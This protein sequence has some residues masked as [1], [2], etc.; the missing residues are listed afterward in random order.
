MPQEPLMF[1]S[2]RRLMSAAGINSIH[3][4]SMP[5]RRF[6]FELDAMNICRDAGVV[7]FQAIVFAAMSVACMAEVA[8]AIEGVPGGKRIATGSLYTC[9]ITEIGEVRCWGA[10]QNGELGDGSSLN[11]GTPTT[12]RGINEPVVAIA[13]GSYHVCV[14]TLSGSV[15]C[16]GLNTQGQLGNNS[17][18]ASATPVDAVGLGSGIVS[19]TAGR[20]HT[21][22]LSAT[23]E[24]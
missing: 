22:A 10:G 11:R 4:D 9:A 16:W 3:L 6:P 15:K 2:K 12:V 13:G 7:L 24:L 21:C 17:Q 8:M 14:V 5:H 23:S 18:T 20:S 1:S 19:I